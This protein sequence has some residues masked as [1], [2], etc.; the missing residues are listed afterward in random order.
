MTV[1]VA[2]GRFAAHQIDQ[3]NGEG[4]LIH[5]QAVPIWTPVEPHVLRP[6]SI[7]FLRGLEVMQ[8]AESVVVSARCQ[9]SASALDQIARPN[10][11]VAA[12]VLV[13]FVEA[14]GD[15]EAGDDSTQEIFGFVGAQNRHAGP[16]QILMPRL[17]VEFLQGLLPVLPV[18]HVIFA[19]RFVRSEQGRESLLSGFRPDSAKA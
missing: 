8:H 6:V 3:Q 18:E 9:Q 13:A 15:G 5:L 4:G 19:R 10:E 7:G 17:L 12:Q 14:P 2:A 1:A 16:V 11:M